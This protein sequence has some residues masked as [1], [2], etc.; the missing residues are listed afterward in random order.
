MED[1]EYQKRFENAS[2]K[3][4]DKLMS[5]TGLEEVKQQFLTIKSTVDTVVRQ[6]ANLKDE[7]FGAAFLGNPGTGQQSSQSA[8]VDVYTLTVAR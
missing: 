5:M 6:N 2:F 7:R 3:S 4:L 1:W 8:H